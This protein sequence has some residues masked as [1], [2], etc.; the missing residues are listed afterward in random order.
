LNDQVKAQERATTSKIKE[1]EKETK[2]L[3]REA[4]KQITILEKLQS[5]VKYVSQG[6][7]RGGSLCPFPR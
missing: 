7:S 4:K 1:A 3:E 5:Q 6:S 2:A